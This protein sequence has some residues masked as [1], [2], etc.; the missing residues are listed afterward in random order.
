MIIR[1]ILSLPFFDRLQNEAGHEF[2]LIALGVIGRRSAAGRIPHPILARVRRRDKRVDF[3]DD[4]VVLFQ[5]GARREAE[6]KKRAL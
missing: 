4:D 2:G 3:T 6:A 5:L 1:E